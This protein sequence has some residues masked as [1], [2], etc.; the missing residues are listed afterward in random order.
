[1]R[2]CVAVVVATLSMLVPGLARA[3]DG[4]ALVDPDSQVSQRN[5]DRGRELY[6]KGDY[7]A[8]IVE[9]RAANEAR[10]SAAL[11]Y[12]IARCYDRLG[13]WQNALAAGPSCLPGARCITT[14]GTTAGTCTVPSPDAC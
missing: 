8:A 2:A 4:G 9:F 3:D 1:M 13:D 12:D 6:A 10:P 11:E 7:T 5:F 14:G